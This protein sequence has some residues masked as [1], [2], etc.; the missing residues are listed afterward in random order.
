MKDRMKEYFDKIYELYHK[1]Y[2]SDNPTI[3]LTGKR[4]VPNISDERI[5]WCDAEL[6]CKIKGSYS[7]FK[8]GLAKNCWHQLGIC[9]GG[10]YA[11]VDVESPN[12]LIFSFFRDGFCCSTFVKKQE[13]TVSDKNKIYEFYVLDKELYIRETGISHEDFINRINAIN[14]VKSYSD[15]VKSS[16][17]EIFLRSDGKP[18]LS[19]RT[20]I[21]RDR[22][23]GFEEKEKEREEEYNKSLTLP[24]IADIITQSINQFEKG[25]PLKEQQFSWIFP[26]EFCIYRNGH[27]MT[28]K[29]LEFFDMKEYMEANKVQYDGSQYI[30]NGKTL[31]YKCNFEL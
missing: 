6:N 15:Y 26:K 12:K 7:D 21:A 14:A 9:D 8:K 24:T 27:Q 1:K 18:I 10:F 25:I 17:I 13:I 22:G 16:N 29:K 2:N 3:K 28:N 5:G 30:F 11:R 4:N 20:E 31:K 23:P 19:N